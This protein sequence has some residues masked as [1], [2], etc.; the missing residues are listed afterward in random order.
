MC[1]QFIWNNKPE[2]VARS[3]LKNDKQNG[4]INGLDIAS[5]V[6][7]LQIRQYL[8]A[9]MNNSNLRILQRSNFKEDITNNSRSLLHKLYRSSIEVYDSL[10]ND[11]I[12][13]L[14]NMEIALL[15]KGKGGQM[16]CL[17]NKYKGA[18]LGDLDW[19]NRGPRD[20]N[21]IRR[22]IGDQ[23]WDS[24][25]LINR[26]T[27]PKLLLI[28]NDKKLDLL[29][30]TSKQLQNLLK[31]SR[32]RTS[33]VGI[34]QRYG[35]DQNSGTNCWGKYWLIR[36]PRLRSIRLKLAWKDVMCN[37]RRSRF[38]ITDDASCTIC[39]KVESVTHQLVDCVN[40]I[41]LWKYFTYY[42]RYDFWALR[43]QNIVE[44]VEFRE[45]YLVE[46][47][48]SL[49]FK[50]LIQIDRSRNLSYDN[51]SAMATTMLKI[52][53]SALIKERCN[54]IAET[55]EAHLRTI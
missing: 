16:L 14:L 22:I 51:Y 12:S 34:G 25:K 13:S 24:V 41:R 52:E 26:S 46:L 43:R 10:D 53:H 29:N 30:A 33:A 48:K 44:L 45:S 32:G 49:T 11:H 36:D 2:R 47:V 8:K 19:Q 18:L 39:G 54:G 31:S 38:K 35:I 5:F 4:G 28:Y 40:A 50:M 9:N 37:E 27:E 6:D 7:S 21:Q 20:C 15:G 3:I 1:Y 55:I 23:L 17:L 42:L